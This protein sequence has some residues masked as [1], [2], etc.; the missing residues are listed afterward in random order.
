MQFWLGDK[1]QNKMHG[2]VTT[3]NAKYI[4]G[5]LTFCI[6]G[7]WSYGA[8][9]TV[10]SRGWGASDISVLGC[11]TLNSLVLSYAGMYWC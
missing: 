4:S 1:M 7:E 3:S 2:T 11:H 10:I 6:D 9:Y 8:S 5:T